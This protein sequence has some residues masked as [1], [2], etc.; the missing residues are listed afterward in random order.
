MS[1][2]EEMDAWDRRHWQWFILWYALALLSFAVAVEIERFSFL[3]ACVVYLLGLLAILPS[4]VAFKRYWDEGAFERN[5][6]CGTHS[7]L[8]ILFL[9]FLGAHWIIRALDLPAA[10]QWA[11]GILFLSVMI[12]SLRAMHRVA[13]LASLSVPTARLIK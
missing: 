3:A 2:V 4:N 5:W 6:E 11:P 12:L 9:G 7:F 1:S 13:F 8:S 10:W